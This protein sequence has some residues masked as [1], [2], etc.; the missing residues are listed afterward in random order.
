MTEVRPVATSS[1]RF[2]LGCAVGAALLIRLDFQF[3]TR[4]L[5]ALLR[6]ASQLVAYGASLEQRFRSMV[7]EYETV[8]DL[9][10][11]VTIHG[12]SDPMSIQVLAYGRRDPCRSGK[13]AVYWIAALKWQGVLVAG[14]TDLAYGD[15]KDCGSRKA[16]VEWRELGRTLRA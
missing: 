6:G 16:L 10:T 1:Q 13:A 5:A 12:T 15:I 11:D 4:H 14:G 2:A 3:K 7:R 8:L 9:Y